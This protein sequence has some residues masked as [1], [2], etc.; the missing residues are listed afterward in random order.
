MKKIK[1]CAHLYF[2]NGKPIRLITHLSDTPK[3]G[4]VHLKSSKMYSDEEFKE[5]I[6]KIFL[7]LIPPKLV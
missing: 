6:R 3:D 2:K 1:G 4:V 5:S 7:N